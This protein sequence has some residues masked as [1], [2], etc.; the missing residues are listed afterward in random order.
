[1]HTH[2]PG[3]SLQE[4]TARPGFLKALARTSAGVDEPY[5]NGHGPASGCAFKRCSA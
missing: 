4:L 2:V 5:K 3:G 1:M